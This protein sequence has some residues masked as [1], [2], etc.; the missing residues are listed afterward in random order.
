MP[1]LLL[2]ILASAI[3]V[4]PV[5]LLA[6]APPDPIQQAIGGV[7][8]LLE[9]RPNDPTLYFYL[10]SFQTQAGERDNALANLAKARELGDGLLPNVD[11]GFDKLKDD[12]AFQSVRAA[13]EQ[14]LPKVADAPVAFRLDDKTFGPEGIAYDSV[15][16]QF[17]IGSVPHKRVVRVSASGKVAPFS[18][19]GDGL[20]QILGVAVD[21]KRRIVYAVSTN[22]LTSGKPLHNAVFGFDLA[23][24]KRLFE[25]AVPLAQQLND[26]AVAP[27]GDLYASDSRSGAIWRIRTS[28]AAGTPAPEVTPFLAA[29]TVGG[30]NGLVVAPDGNTLYVAHSTGVVRVDTAT[31]KLDKL[32][33]PPRQTIAAIDGLYL[34]KGDLIGIQN[35]TNPGRVIRL[36]LNPAGTEIM[37][38]DTLQSHHNA[39]F[40]SPTTGAIAG[41]AL[42]VLGTTQLPRY[43][44]KGE[45]EGAGALKK[46]AVVR[47]PLEKK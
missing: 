9:K 36:R 21:A 33:P 45:V 22:A 5:P 14:A 44:D 8:A 30:S 29:G 35:V 10:A 20:H 1:R 23:S 38:I 28:A 3:A 37:G 32:M 13:F 40:D 4:G 16:K 24:G 42:Y 43:N 39:A 31:G 6:Q 41:N 12:P 46:P 25:Y 27:N 19:A 17:F 11:F 34:W 2:V 26:V 18:A 47:V 15:S 7:K